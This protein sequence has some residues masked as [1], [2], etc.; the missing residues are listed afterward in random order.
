MAQTTLLIDTLKLALKEKGITYAM[1]AKYLN[2]SEASIKRLFAD[3]NISLSRLDKICALLNMEI[4]DL[5]KLAEQRQSEISELSDE[6]EKQLVAE[7]KLLLMAYMLLNEISFADICK[8][9]QIDEHEGIQLLAKLDRIG[10]IDLLPGNRVKLHTSRNFKW[11][12]GGPID[13]LFNEHIRNEFFKSRFSGENE[14]MQFASAMIS[15]ATLKKMQDKI[16]KLS[17]EFNQMAK[18]DASLPLEDKIGC[19]LVSAIRP[20]QFSLFAKLKR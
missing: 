12:S 3:E 1:V 13:S 18:E 17:H 2:L 8:H 16:R 15:H 5:C 19:S 10:F 7:P 20:W 4:S 11:R 6:Q 14:S 9:Y